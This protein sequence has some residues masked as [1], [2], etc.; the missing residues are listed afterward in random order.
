MA[1]EPTAALVLAYL[2]KM[3]H[4]TMMEICAELDKIP[5]TELHNLISKTNVLRALTSLAIQD[6]KFPIPQ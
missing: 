6:Q 1:T 3:N 5:V 4:H 2:R